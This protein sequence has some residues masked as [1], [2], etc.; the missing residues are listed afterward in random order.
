[1]S[2]AVSLWGVLVCAFFFSVMDVITLNFVAK[3]GSWWWKRMYENGVFHF[4]DEIWV[5][6]LGFPFGHHHHTICIVQMCYCC[7]L[8]QKTKRRKD[9]IKLS[10]PFHWICV[11][12]Y[13]SRVW[14]SWNA[15]LN[16]VIYARCKRIHSCHSKLSRFFFQIIEV[17]AFPL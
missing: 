17:A 4:L 9:I 7:S 11:N 12:C 15:L 10:I 14:F 13:G 2:L 8:S 6:M 16:L 3:L 1:M 5:P